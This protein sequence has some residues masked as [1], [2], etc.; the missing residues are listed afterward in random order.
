[1]QPLAHTYCD[2]LLVIAHT[3]PHFLEYA[4]AIAQYLA[5]MRMSHNGGKC[6]YVTSTRINSIM[7]HLDP[8]NASIP[9]ACLMGKSNVPYLGLALDRK[10]MPFMKEKHVVRGEALL[11]WCKNTL[12]PASVPHEVMAAVVG[13]IV[14]YA[15]PYLL[16][17]AEEVVRLNGA[18]KT[19]ALQCERLPKDLSTV[20]VRYGKGLKLTDIRVVCRDSMVV[21]VAELTHHRSAVIKGAPRG[22]RDDMHKQYGVCGQFMD[23][24]Q[25]FASHVGECNGQNGD[26]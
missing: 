23:P 16:A 13:G 11:G 14:R 2:D 3:L 25:A 12:A 17:T 15:A 18:I 6:V 26:G 5:D 7:V 4:K 24:S 8:N 19:A 10:V 21:I 20:V 22:L 9:W 1:M